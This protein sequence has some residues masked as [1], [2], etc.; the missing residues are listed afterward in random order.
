MD[1]SIRKYDL[2]IYFAIQPKLI[3]FTLYFHLNHKIFTLII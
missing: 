1:F 3:C 2:N